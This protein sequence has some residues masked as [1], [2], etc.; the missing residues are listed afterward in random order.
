MKSIAETQ[1]Q[2]QLALLRKADPPRDP[3]LDQKAAE[4]KPC[5]RDTTQGKI[6]L[7]NANER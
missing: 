7:K 3:V 1:P 4:A 6:C 2:L 5:A